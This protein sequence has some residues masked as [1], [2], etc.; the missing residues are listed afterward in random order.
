MPFLREALLGVTILIGLLLLALL[1]V[2]WRRRVHH[3]HTVPAPGPAPEI[4]E[5]APRLAGKYVATTVAGEPYERIAA[6]GLGFR[7]NAVAIVDRAGVLVTRTGER[8]IW[9][10]RDDLVGVDRAT[11]T[12]DRVV[13]GDGLHL[14]RWRLG[15]RE[16]D[17]YL[18]L[19]AP[20]VFD[21][22]LADL[23]LIA[24]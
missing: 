14:I 18:R 21:A 16:V 24:S 12:I 22:A 5:E 20:A 3:Q 10:P 4:A 23:E 7:G 13:E 8:D 15:D 11:W 2:G 9:I 1:V 19:D 17:T 6:G